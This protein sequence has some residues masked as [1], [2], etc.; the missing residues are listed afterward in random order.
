MCLKKLAHEFL[1]MT[2][3]TPDALCA[4]LPDIFQF[5]HINQGLVIFAK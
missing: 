3:G 2:F 1:K 5:C 4:K